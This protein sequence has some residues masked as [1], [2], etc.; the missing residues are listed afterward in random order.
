MKLFECDIILSE[1]SICVDFY[2]DINMSFI[3]NSFICAQKRCCKNLKEK[4]GFP[5]IGVWKRGYVRPLN[6]YYCAQTG[7][8]QF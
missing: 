5:Y 1:I 3:C 8:A 2:V 7:F 4:V 6:V